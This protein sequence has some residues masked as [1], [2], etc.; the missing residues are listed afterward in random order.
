M[1]LI[2]IGTYFTEP[3]NTQV[4]F[5]VT[6]AFRI[7][8]T[9]LQPEI[10]AFNLFNAGSVLTMNTRYGPQWQYALAVLGPRVVKFGLQVYF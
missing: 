1:E 8:K 2:P 6:R 9:R 10:D 5:R 7:G 3:R 4:D